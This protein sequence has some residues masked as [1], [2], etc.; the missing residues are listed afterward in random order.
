MD[1][2]STRAV[3]TDMRTADRVGIEVATEIAAIVV[4]AAR[5]GTI[6]SAWKAAVVAVVAGVIAIETA[7][8]IGGRAATGLARRRRETAARARVVGM[9][10]GAMGIAGMATGEMP[11]EVTVTAAM[12]ATTVTAMTPTAVKVFALRAVAVTA[13]VAMEIVRMPIAVTSTG[14]AIGM[15]T[16]RGSPAA[17]VMQ[18]NRVGKPSVR[19]RR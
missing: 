16:V 8:K 15:A 19:M 6:V 10:I 17:A 14:M 11:T 5:D 13:D 1:V 9:G 7:I 12:A 4:I 3:V 18:G 2:A